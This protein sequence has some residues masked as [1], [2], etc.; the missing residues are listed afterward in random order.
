[1]R[2]LERHE[3]HRFWGEA[4]VN[5]QV[6]AEVRGNAFVRQRS[7]RVLEASRSYEGGTDDCPWSLQCEPDVTL[8]VILSQ[9]CA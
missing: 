5:M 6:E 7:P 8:T 3:I 1:M 4:T 9:Q 2:K